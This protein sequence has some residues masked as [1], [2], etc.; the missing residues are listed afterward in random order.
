MIRV[1]SVHILIL[2]VMQVRLPLITDN[3]E[4][5]DG[6]DSDTFPQ[7]KQRTGMI[8]RVKNSENGL[9]KRD[10]DWNCGGVWDAN[11]KA[12]HCKL[13]Y[14]FCCSR[15]GS[16]TNRIRHTPLHRESPQTAGVYK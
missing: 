3:L 1:R 11:S 7:V 5:R 14:P 15:S 16:E 12:F 2:E 4:M 9:W 10:V 6:S 8:I 13:Y